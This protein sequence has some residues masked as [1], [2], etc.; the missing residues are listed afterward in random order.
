MVGIHTAVCGATPLVQ[1]RQVLDSHSSC[2]NV[3]RERMNDEVV[4]FDWVGTRLD[5][6]VETPLLFFAVLL[7]V[8]VYESRCGHQI[9]QNM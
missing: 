7:D 2:M 8:D 6:D 3:T 9:S 5:I 1:G 4:L